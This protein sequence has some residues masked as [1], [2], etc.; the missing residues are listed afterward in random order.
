MALEWVAV[1]LPVGFAALG[2]VAGVLPLSPRTLAGLSPAAG[3]ALLAA[4]LG[5][6]GGA[7][8]GGSLSFGPFYLDALSAY[9]TAI[10]AVVGCAA[11]LF[12][13]G[14][15]QAEH[16]SG[17][18]GV[19]QVRLYYFW[20]YIF[21]AS[22]FLV[23]LAGNL[24]L[25]WVA[26]EGTTLATAFLVGLYNTK[27][28][29]EA[30]WKYTILCTV[31]IAI[32]L[33]G[34]IVLYYAAL[35]VAGG[36]G[37]AL[38]WPDVMAAAGRLDPGLVRLAFVLA[39]VGY[40]TKAGLAPMHTWLPDAHSQAPAPVSGLLSGVLLSSAMYAVLRFYAIAAGALGPAYP[41]ALL[42]AFG[43][44]SIAV[45]TPFIIVQRD[46]K[47]LLAYSSVEHMGVVAVGAG[48]AGLGGPAAALAGWGAVFHL[49]SHACTKA[50]LFFSAGNL[51]HAWGT[52]R[53]DRIHG[54][55]RL[56]PLTGTALL[57][58]GFALTGMPPFALFASE[59]A[60]A[61]GGFAQGAYWASM[62]FLVLLAVIFG[63]MTYYA[64]SVAFG[65]PTD[66]NGA[67]HGVPGEADQAGTGRLAR[68]GGLAG[69][70]AIWLPLA[71]VLLLGLYLP[72]PLNELIQRAA[73]ILQGGV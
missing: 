50:A 25:L 35:P 10:I 41:G 59:F 70:L 23:V 49:F 13:S 6:T 12:S 47:R 48:L 26:I 65:K 68:D 7:L 56:V 11:C 72:P 32:A 18:L 51:V 42:L 37:R 67:H 62:L 2:L 27:A 21:I 63:G 20:F 60:I 28:S 39:L 69:A 45:A 64:M 19:R 4:G 38:S 1:S 53:L 44:L 55:L 58:G 43:L 29:I 15:I 57:L 24:G 22:M 5:V 30:A 3:V 9:M 31:G 54:A 36:P 17:E 66:G 33:L 16:Q 71:L 73:A 52:R 61:S 8:A 40:G 34:T 46:L 14:H